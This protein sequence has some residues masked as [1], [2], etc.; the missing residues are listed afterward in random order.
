MLR[1]AFVALAV[2]MAA[3]SAR[4]ADDE[5]PRPRDIEALDKA[6]QAA[7]DR[8]Q[9]AIA[10]VLVSRSDVYQRWFGEPASD[11]PCKLGGFTPAQAA[12]RVKDEDQRQ[13][14][15]LRK[16]LEPR[17]GR[18]NRSEQDDAIKRF[19]DLSDS[20]YVPESYGSGVVIHESGL[21]L[22]NYHVIRGATK[23][24]IRLADGKGSYA[25]I[26]AAEPRC[27]LAVLRLIDSTL[28]PLAVI[29]RGDGGKLKKGQIVLSLANPFAAGMK[30]GSPSASWGIVSN[31]RRRAAPPAATESDRA[32]IKLYYFETLIQTDCRLNAGCSGGALLN[33]KGELVGLTTALAAVAGSDTPGGFTIP[34]D[35]NNRAYVDRLEKGLPIDFGFLGVGFQLNARGQASGL[36]VYPGSPAA[37]AGLR[38]GD[39]IV[40]VNGRPVHD[41]DEIFLAISTLLAGSEAR[42]EA[43]SPGAEPRMLTATLDKLHVPGVVY[44]SQRPAAVRG[45]RVDYTSVVFQR[46]RLPN[47]PRGVFVS[48]VKPGSAA[49]TAR[50]QGAII[51]RVNGQEIDGPTDFYRKVARL[52][53]PLEVTILNRTEPSGVS[54]VKLE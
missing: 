26:H 34:M 5:A 25:D 35:A 19:F 2:A 45:L 12:L 53:G 40:S 24:F 21:V 33:L 37:R 9:P 43:R 29:R 18:A 7:I 22:T 32:K 8:A 39:F 16:S 13:Y 48:E 51:T 3:A 47:I 14:D 52:K 28:A 38:D 6:F 41:N 4:G 44:A 1:L 50:L 17:A 30:D 20:N 11:D 31:L 23:V 27:D 42:I 49:D 46:D 15:E 36:S 54:T 10:C